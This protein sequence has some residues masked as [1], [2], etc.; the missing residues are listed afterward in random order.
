MKRRPTFSHYSRLPILGPVQSVEQ[1]AQ[2]YFKPRGLWLSVDGPDDWRAW[3]EGNNFNPDSLA[4]RYRVTIDWT[5]ILWL[6]GAVHLRQFSEEFGS[7]DP[8]HGSLWIEWARVAAAGNAGIVIAPYSWEC[9]ME[10]LWYYS[11]DCASGCVWDA[12]AVRRVLPR[13]P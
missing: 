1:I 8:R 10:L 5:R 13:R 11:W 12:S 6:T 2:P 7:R 3:C 9:R 4:Y